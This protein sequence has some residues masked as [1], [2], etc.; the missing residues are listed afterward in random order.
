MRS[1]TDDSGL[2]SNASPGA[3]YYPMAQG[4]AYQDRRARV[5]MA[6]LLLGMQI[7]LVFV[8]LK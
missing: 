3:E 7:I 6:V 8:D 5:C 4:I 1:I 2:S